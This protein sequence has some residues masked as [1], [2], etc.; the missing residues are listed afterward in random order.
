L[1]EEEIQKLLI[2]ILLGFSVGF[3][4]NND[5]YHALESGVIGIMMIGV[6]YFGRNIE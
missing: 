6:Y 4:L 3:M 1:G 2:T 5:W